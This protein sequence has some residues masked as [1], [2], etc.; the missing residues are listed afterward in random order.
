MLARPILATVLF[1]A[2]NF[3]LAACGLFSAM[4]MQD[5]APPAPAYSPILTSELDPEP[6]YLAREIAPCTPV[7]DS[8]IDPCEPGREPLR[9]T[10]GMLGLGEEPHSVQDFLEGSLDFVPHIVLRGTYLPGTVRCATTVFRPRPYLG[11]DAY[12]FLRGD[13]IIMCY[14]D[15]RVNAYFLG[16]GPPT[17]TVKVAHDFYPE[18]WGKAETEELKRLWEHALIE[19]E[20]DII[21]FEDFEIGPIPGREAMLFIGPTVGTAVEVWEV[22]ETWNIE[23]R[24][25]GTVIAVHPYRDY[26]SLEDHRAALEME[27]PRFSQEVI[28]A[29]ESRVTANGGRVLPELG[30]PMLITDVHHLRQFFTEVGAYD[31]PDGPPAQPPPA[32]GATV[33][34]RSTANR[35]LVQDCQTLLAAKDALRG[36]AALNWSADLAIGS[37]TGVTVGGTPQRVTTLSLASS[38]LNGTIPPELGSLSGLTTLDLSNNTLTGSIPAT[39]GELSD[40][41]TLKLSGNSLSGCIP[42]ALRDVATSDLATI[43]LSYCDM[44]TPPPAPGGVSLALADSVFTVSWNPVNGVERYEAQHRTD[45]G[46]WTTLPETEETTATYTPEDSLTCRTSYGFRVRA[47]GDGVMH[48]AAWGDPSGEVAHNTDA[49][50]QAPDFDPD[51]YSF[52]LG[53]SAL[54]GTLVGTVSAVDLDEGD[55]VAYSITAGNEDGRFTLGESSGEITLVAKLDYQTATSYSLTVL[56]E[57]G[58]GGEDTASVAITVASVCRNGTVIPSPADNPGLG[59]LPHPVR[60]EGHAGRQRQPGLERL[61]GLGRM[62]RG[63]GRRGL[64]PSAGIGAEGNGPGREH[65]CGLGGSQPVAPVGAGR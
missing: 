58:N 60:G 29:Q 9:A 65:P 30:H 24:N 3:A 2:L 38:S 42:P 36:A 25:D 34:G 20:S 27:L 10:G 17:L 4:Q 55:V 14:A 49:C 13:L 5:A 61:H 57:D 23:Q 39:L 15:V 32:C 12:G 41:T 64:G 33:S 46:G 54:T 63:E 18:T 6:T 19:G 50:N 37:W 48:S 52:T 59:G 16:S 35:A 43:G 31:H 21:F 1:A 62:A 51:S 11:P 28:A 53:E 8:S 26:Y 45:E 40:L 22:F 56:A 7:T 47:Y 44:L